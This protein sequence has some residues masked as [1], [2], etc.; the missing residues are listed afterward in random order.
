[1][2][3]RLRLALLFALVTVLV[4]GVAGIGFL[5]QLRVSLDASLD[6]SLVT[7][8]SALV[9]EVNAA[10]LGS[11]RLGQDEEP[12]QFLTVDG[13]V[14]ASSPELADRPALSAAQRL[15]V[16]GGQVLTFTTELTEE[17]TR[18]LARTTGVPGT[19]VVVGM[20]TDIS[21]AAADHVESA[22]LLGGPP[23]VLVA[24]LG[25][26]LLAGAALRPVERMRRETADISEHDNSMQ[27]AVP[28][29]RDEIAALATTM[30]ALLGRLRAAVTRERGFVADAGH[31]LRT[32]LA[33]LR[34]ELELA[35]RPGRS[36]AEL[37]EAV[38]AAG[39]ETERLI[40][41]SENL[42]LLARAEGEQTLVRANPTPLHELLTAA[43]RAANAG[44]ADR[45]IS[46]EVDCPA[47]LTAVADP[48]RLRQA[49]DNLLDNALRHSPSGGQVLLRAR[50]R[51]A[52]SVLEISVRD[53]GPGFPAE[54]IPHA[55]ERFR[56]ADNA[57]ARTDGGAGLGLA[58]VAAIATAHD[59]KATAGNHPTGGAI[60]VLHLPAHQLERP[61]PAVRS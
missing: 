30:N 22:I 18:V 49:I 53:H 33:M 2:P 16:G 21:D 43:A 32:P 19:L 50:E 28:P 29:T 47:E 14:L 31:E 45:S 48:D 11:L 61:R 58:I 26:W 27:L 59:G 36:R 20:G 4:I 51:A 3:L 37:A 54:F 38:A 6:S 55:F 52:P 5:L 17:R 60:V 24:G 46:I 13:R 12:A 35:A 39:L 23:A 41:L 25:A 15:A 34:A 56:R 9:D 42:L 10:G 8:A 57:R 40:R 7:R 1:M 44:A